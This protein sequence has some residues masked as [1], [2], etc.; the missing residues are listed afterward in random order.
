MCIRDR[1]NRRQD[2]TIIKRETNTIHSKTELSYVPCP[3]CKQQILT[4]TL[5]HHISFCRDAFKTKS[6][7]KCTACELFRKK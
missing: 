6:Q 1:F 5:H 3:Y 7:G 4:N 2:N